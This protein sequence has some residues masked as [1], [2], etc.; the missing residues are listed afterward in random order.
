MVRVGREAVSNRIPLLTTEQGIVHSWEDHGDGRFTIHSSQDVEPVLELNKAM[1][2]HN[3]GY[4]PSREWRRA[5]HIPA[6]L[7]LK[8]RQ[9]IGSDPLHPQNRAWLLRRLNDSDWRTLRTASGVL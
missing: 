4:S 6:I 8:W 5:A 9:E 2:T 3:D 7:L 1:A